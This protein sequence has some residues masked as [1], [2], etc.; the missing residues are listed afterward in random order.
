MLSASAT[1][2]AVS[3]DFCRRDQL[4][5]VY[6]LW[7]YLYR[8]IVS[9]VVRF[10]WNLQLNSH[11]KPRLGCPS[12]PEYQTKSTQ[13]MLVETRKPTLTYCVFGTFISWFVINTDFRISGL[14][15]HNSMCYKQTI[16]HCMISSSI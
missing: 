7:G 12:S 4:R 13:Q 9:I 2:F 3:I 11:Y 1:Q 8:K 14:Q 10:A 5:S 6:K 16:R 15:I